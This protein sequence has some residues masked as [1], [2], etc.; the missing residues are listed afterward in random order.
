MVL[1]QFYTCACAAKFS[2]KT[3]L[4]YLVLFGAFFCIML[5]FVLQCFVLRNL[6]SRC[7]CYRKACIVA[8]GVRRMQVYWCVNYSGNPFIKQYR[9]YDDVRAALS[10]SSSKWA[11]IRV[12]LC[13]SVLSTIHV[14][15]VLHS[16]CILRF[17]ITQENNNKRARVEFSSKFG[18]RNW[19]KAAT[20]EHHLKT[21]VCVLRVFHLEYNFDKMWF[22][23]VR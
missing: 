12:H 13:A 16:V 22:Q 3:K 20:L 9:H 21:V 15:L 10:L 8:P 11:R 7:F 2:Y 23:H 4:I 6:R 5:S 14:G 1:F 18:F 19:D 17:R